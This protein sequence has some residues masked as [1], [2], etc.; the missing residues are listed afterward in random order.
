MKRWLLLAALAALAA[1]RLRSPSGN[2]IQ[3]IT[4]ERLDTSAAP[5]RK[6]PSAEDDSARVPHI[7]PGDLQAIQ[8]R[9]KEQSAALK[10]LQAQL[11][12]GLKQKRRLELTQ[13]LV[14][15][16]AQLG[17]ANRAL[18]SLD[19]KVSGARESIKRL[20]D[21]Q[22][23]IED[24]R[25][26]AEAENARRAR[27]EDARLEELRK[28]TA[29]ESGEVTRLESKRAAVAAAVGKWKEYVAQVSA[30]AGA[31]QRPSSREGAPLS[32]SAAAA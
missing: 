11:D 29:K 25:R 14:A 30:A 3:P 1:A 23:E 16:V 26:R 19:A 12:E 9:M 18:A 21:S 20:Q 22:V 13:R 8:D 27:E 31:G 6:E 28:A 10:T 24:S 4:V 7:S 17:R 2:T 32:S 15:G 5:A